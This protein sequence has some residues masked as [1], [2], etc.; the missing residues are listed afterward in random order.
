MTW[1]LSDP[2]CHINWIKN[3]VL[4]HN[5]QSI[6]SYLMYITAEFSSCLYT[7]CLNDG[8]CHN[9]DGKYNFTC[10]CSSGWEGELDP[11]HIFRA[12]VTII[13]VHSFLAWQVKELSFG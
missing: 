7:P 5:K 4:I 9:L 10:S 13:H 2:V 8:T 11:N 1:A 6:L 3:R 12:F